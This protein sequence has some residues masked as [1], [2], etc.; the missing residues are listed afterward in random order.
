M[1]SKSLCKS[2]INNKVIRVG[3]TLGMK[4]ISKRKEMCLPVAHNL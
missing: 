1:E 3:N 2:P 4:N